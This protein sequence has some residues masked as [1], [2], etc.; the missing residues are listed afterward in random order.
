MSADVRQAQRGWML[1]ELA[2]HPASGRQ[3]ADLLD[4]R[5]VDPRGYEALQRAARFVEHAQRRVAGACQVARRLQHSRQHGLEVHVRQQAARDLQHAAH[6]T[7]AHSR[8]PA[9]AQ[10]RLRRLISRRRRPDRRSAGRSV[11]RNAS[12]P[13]RSS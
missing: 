9:A 11:V 6:D 12:G 3:R 7:V 10:S 8:S 13:A 1:D 4:H 2:Q 5:V